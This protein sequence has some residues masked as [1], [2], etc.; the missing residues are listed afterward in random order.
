[1]TMPLTY[2]EFYS[3][4]D[5][6]HTAPTYSKATEA[7]KPH[8]FKTWANYQIPFQPSGPISF[9]ET[10]SLRVFYAAE[11]D[12]DGHL[13]RFTKFSRITNATSLTIS[14]QKPAP[15]VTIYL[16][17]ALDNDENNKPGTLIEY[18]E[19]EGLSEYFMGTYNADK[20]AYT[21]SYIRVVMVFDD[22]YEYR[23]DGTLLRRS[24]KKA[25]GSERIVEFDEHGREMESGLPSFQP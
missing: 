20:V 1:M 17:V 24:M 19:T 16:T 3:G 22:Q 8:Y 15:L 25:D 21:L 4:S 18:D 23:N 14:G 13:I 5:Y 9:S 7:A 6:A 11:Y 2:A 10:A 12:Q